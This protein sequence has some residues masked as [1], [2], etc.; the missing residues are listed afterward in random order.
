MHKEI[1]NLPFFF[2]AGN[3]MLKEINRPFICTFFNMFAIRIS[4]FENGTENYAVLFH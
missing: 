2:N 3:C 4:E 1:L